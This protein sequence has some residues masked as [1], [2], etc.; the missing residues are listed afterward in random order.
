MNGL[1]LNLL[2]IVVETG[3]ALGVAALL[4]RERTKAAAQAPE[5]IPVRVRSRR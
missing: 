4:L 2:E 1:E 5:L 3:V